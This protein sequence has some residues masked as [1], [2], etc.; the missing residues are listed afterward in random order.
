MNIVTAETEAC[1]SDV[2]C[3]ASLNYVYILFVDNF[4]LCPPGLS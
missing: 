1:L 4:N 3:Q 2:S